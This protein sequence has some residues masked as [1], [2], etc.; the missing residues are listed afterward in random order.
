[1]SNSSWMALTMGASPLVVQ[2]AHEMKS[3]DPSY[4]LALT[5]MTMVWESSLAGAE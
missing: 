5:P 2:E 4:S 3:S 1:M